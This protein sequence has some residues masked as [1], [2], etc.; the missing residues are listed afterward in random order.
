MQ[1]R[2]FEVRYLHMIKQCQKE[3]L[4]F[5]VVAL[6]GGEEV[7]RPGIEESIQTVG[8]LAHLIDV[9]QMQQGLLFVQCKGGQRF[10]VQANERGAF[11]LWHAQV[12]P[13]SEDIATD[14]PPDLQPIADKLGALIA[15]AQK[16]GAEGQLPLTRPY[17]LD[18]CGWV[19]NQWAMLLALNGQEKTALLSE[20]DPL[21]RL[22]MIKLLLA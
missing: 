2:I 6:R 18:E 21:T 5:G 17:R 14:I 4:P 12:V 22:T 1:L 20:D 11:G 8:C 10:H 16:Q 13:K 3:N 7:Q 9:V 15:N 19:A